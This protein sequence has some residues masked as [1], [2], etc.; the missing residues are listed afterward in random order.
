MWYV[1]GNRDEDLFEQADR[2]IADRTNAREHISFGY[3]IHR[4]IGARLAELQL[5][6]LME[7]MAERRLEIELAGPPVREANPFLSNILSVPVYPQIAIQIGPAQ[8]Q[9]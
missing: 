8:L 2:F 6:I 5:R 4:C 9:R 1:S 7:E 3:G